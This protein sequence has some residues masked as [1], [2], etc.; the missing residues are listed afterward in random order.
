MRLSLSTIGLLA[1]SSMTSAAPSALD[2]EINI[3]LDSKRLVARQRQYS[4]VDV[5][6]GLQAQCLEDLIDLRRKEAA[7]CNIAGCI[8]AFAAVVVPCAVAFGTEFADVAADISCIIAIPSFE[9]A[10]VFC[11]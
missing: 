4:C 11:G 8:G 7:G 6:I 5:D 10:C 1:L 2:S 9:G 3:S